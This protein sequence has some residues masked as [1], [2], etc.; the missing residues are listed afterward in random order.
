[1]LSSANRR[2]YDDAPEV[3][4]RGAMAVVEFEHMS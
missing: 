1:M 4:A 3:V 2:R